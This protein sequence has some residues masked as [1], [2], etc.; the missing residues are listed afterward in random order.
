MKRFFERCGVWW[1]EHFWLYCPLVLAILV[2]IAVVYLKTLSLYEGVQIL[3]M[4]TL[5]FVTWKYAIETAKI[6]KANAETVEQMRLQSERPYIVGLIKS[7]I[8]P[9]EATLDGLIDRYEK[10]KFEWQHMDERAVKAVKFQI[11]ELELFQSEDGYYIPWPSL[12]ISGLFGQAP[13]DSDISYYVYLLER[14]SHLKELIDQYN[15][16]A[17]KLWAQLYE[18]A[19]VLAKSNLR[20]ALKGLL[21]SDKQAISLAKVN[22]S[23]AELPRFKQAVQENCLH[24][25]SSKLLMENNAYAEFMAINWS[26]W[27]ES[28]IWSFWRD[29][30]DNLMQNIVTG[31][32][33]KQLQASILKKSE[34]LAN[35]T[36]IIKDEVLRI[37]KDYMRRYNIRP[38]EIKLDYAYPEYLS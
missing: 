2:T 26:G 33:I 38:E 17:E 35:H 1:R 9:L 27:K 16:E 31:E 29:W 36:R 10:R 18:L 30:Q 6:R 5:V 11:K 20:H 7:A 13:S 25:A 12:T 3:L 19:V 14:N 8:Q 23:G 32:S 15:P 4:V 34:T 28:A 37:K 24:L 22:L 21:S